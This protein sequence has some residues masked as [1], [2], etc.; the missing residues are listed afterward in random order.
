MGPV[1]VANLALRALGQGKEIQNLQT[2]NTAEARAVRRVYD[3]CV[4]KTFRDFAWPFA[5][6]IGVLELVEENPNREWAFS[7]RKPSG[8]IFFRRILSG[9]RNDNQDS[10]IPFRIISDDNGDLILT[11]MQEAEGEWTKL[12][13]SVDKWP[14]DFRSAV[15]YRIAAEIAPSITSGDPFKLGQRAISFYNAELGRAQANAGNEERP[16][17]PPETDLVRARD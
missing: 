5:T 15:A 11:D 3:D 7:Y 1:D 9:V 6:R 14:A 12:I 13:E 2:E 16:E 10:A 8:T 4:K 17:R